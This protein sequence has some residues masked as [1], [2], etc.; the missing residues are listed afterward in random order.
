MASSRTGGITA[1]HG[2]VVAQALAWAPA[3]RLVGPA[4]LLDDVRRQA[5]LVARLYDAEVGPR[6]GGLSPGDL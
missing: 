5:G 2:A 4:D 3:V 6:V 1:S